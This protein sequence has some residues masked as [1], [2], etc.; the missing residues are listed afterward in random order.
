M[1][2]LQGEPWPVGRSRHA[3]CCLNYG[4][5]H[6]KLLVFGGV[7]NADK[8]LRDMWVFDVDTGQWTEVRVVPVTTCTVEYF[9]YCTPS[10]AFN[11]L[12]I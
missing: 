2:A 8:T 5:D 12:F 9:I 1:E 7:D 10:D 11:C 3:A 6:P 4:E